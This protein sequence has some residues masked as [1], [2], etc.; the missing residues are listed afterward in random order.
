MREALFEKPWFGMK[1]TITGDAQCR[2]EFNYDP[3]CA[4]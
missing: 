3:K 2:V 1:L 4:G